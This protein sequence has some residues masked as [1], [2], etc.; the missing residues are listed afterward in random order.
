M[1]PKAQ[2]ALDEFVQSGRMKL[3]K[4]WEPVKFIFEHSNRLK[5]MARITLAGPLGLYLLQFCDVDEHIKTMFTELLLCLE[6]IQAKT[7]TPSSLNKL[8]IRLVLVL[9][10]CEASLPLYWNTSVRHHLLHLVSFLRRC[11]PFEAFS[12]AAFERFHTIFKKLV[13]ARCGVMQS[14]VNHYAMLVMGDKWR[15]TP[16]EE[17]EE[18]EV[19]FATA[20]YASSIAAASDVDFTAEHHDVAVG[21]ILMDAVL[22]PGLY[23]HV[24]DQWALKFKDPYD[25][26]RDRYRRER[27]R[28]GLPGWDGSKPNAAQLPTNWSPPNPELTPDER[29]WLNMT[30]K[31]Q[32]FTKVKLNDKYEFRTMRSELTNK[33]S[34][35]VIKEVYYEHDGASTYAYGRI[36]DMFI[37][38]AYPDGP[39]LQLAKVQWMTELPA[40]SS[41]GLRQVRYDP[42]SNFNKNCQ[43]VDLKNIARYN[44]AL[45]PQDLQDPACAVFAVIDP[46]GRLGCY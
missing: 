30:P 5:M 25:K 12:M 15:C 9:A 2:K 22:D 28:A 16:D 3:P 44:I 38:Q 31:V 11:G 33:T 39:K 7:Q 41:T 4:A 40:V 8:E 45:L 1:S 24:Q 35:S 27:K 34:N 21:G 42:M 36:E 46:E 29:K 43:V 19:A 13:R 20:P 37:H 23:E 17:G 10:D 6:A 26:M 32:R 14:L 18:G